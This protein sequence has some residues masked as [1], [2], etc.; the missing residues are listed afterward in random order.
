[1]RYLGIAFENDVTHIPFKSG[2]SDSSRGSGPRQT[3]EEPGALAAGEQRRADLHTQFR[4][5]HKT[6]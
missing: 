5:T 3:D 2:H 4:P 1:M 6:R